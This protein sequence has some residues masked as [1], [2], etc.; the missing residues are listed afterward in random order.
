MSQ[1]QPDP[2]SLEARIRARA[3]E[4]GFDAVGFARA[5]GPLEEDFERYLGWVEQGLHGSMDY[6]AR[7]REVRAHLAHPG[8]L[9]SARSVICVTQRVRGPKENEP[10]EGSL[11]STVARYARGRDYHRTMRK[12]LRAL[13]EFVRQLGDAVEARALLDIEPVLERAWARRAGL[14]FIG[15]NGLLITP[16]QGSFFL[17][18]EVVTNL[19]LAPAEPMADRCGSCRA[20]LDACPTQA[21]VGPFVLDA[22]KCVSYLNIEHKEVPA[23]GLRAGVS[24]KLFGCDVCRQISTRRD[25]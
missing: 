18:G 5:D 1:H 9:A 8:I 20:C 4:L 12:R 23:T 22:R 17:L 21:F 19:L 7:N 15:K 3:Q 10:E 16:G 24:G 13:A 25:E 2:G 11:L 14:G 6:L